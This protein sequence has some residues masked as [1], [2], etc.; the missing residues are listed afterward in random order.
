MVY[1]DIEI[2]EKCND[3]PCFYGTEGAWRDECQVLHKDLKEVEGKTI[4]NTQNGVYERPSWCPMKRGET[5]EEFRKS[6][7]KEI[8]DK[9]PDNEE[10]M[11][12]TT[13]ITEMQ[14]EEVIGFVIRKKIIIEWCEVKKHKAE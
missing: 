4:W 13:E 5:M 11:A 10:I 12:G 14:A 2:P 3:C 7:L 8:E 9:I 1:L 6:V